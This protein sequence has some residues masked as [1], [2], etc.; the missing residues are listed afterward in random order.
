MKANRE[1]LLAAIIL[2]LIVA[3]GLRAPAFVTPSSL[4]GVLTDTSFLFMLAL[5]QMGVLL[6]RGIDLS[7]AANLA[8]SGMVV[9]LV[10]HNAPGFPIAGIIVLAILFGAALGLI[11]AA[12]I[13]GLG[14]PPIVVTLGTLAVYRGMIFVINPRPKP[15]RIGARRGSARSS[16]GS[17]GTPGAPL[18]SRDCGRN[19]SNR[20]SA[21]LC[22]SNVALTALKSLDRCK[23]MYALRAAR[24]PF[25]GGQSPVSAPIRPPA[26]KGPCTR[27]HS[28]R[29][30]ARLTAWRSA[31]LRDRTGRGRPGSLRPPARAGAPSGSRRRRRNGPKT[32]PSRRSAGGTAPR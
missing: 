12:L 23:K 17:R 21:R 20:A 29:S 15:L 31:R 28:T 26:P 10:N 32:W 13:A 3:V 2:A 27:V 8:L 1:I 6:T 19:V 25:Q 24:E 7:V 4:L 11:N 22:E 5:A 14:I 30:R 16:S 18:S 9:A